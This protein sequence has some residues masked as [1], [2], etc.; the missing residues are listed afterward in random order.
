LVVRGLSWAAMTYAFS[1]VPPASGYAVADT[2]CAEHVTAEP[3]TVAV[4]AM[5]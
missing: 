2:G 4:N 5:T 1:S 3:I